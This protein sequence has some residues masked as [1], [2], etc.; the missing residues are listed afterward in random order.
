VPALIDAA[1]DDNEQVRWHATKALSQLGDARAADVLIAALDDTNSGI[2]WLA[3]EGLVAAGTDIVE[4]L[5]RALG[6]RTVG[7]RFRQGVYH[8]FNKLEGETE[9]QTTWC[10]RLARR[11]R[12][13][14]TE[15]MPVLAS[16]SLSEWR[17]M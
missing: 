17:D 1:R 9:P 16:R 4:P 2:R 6:N 12:R 11:V 13:E 15:N 3:A 5:L 7:A 14:P 10:R 8:V